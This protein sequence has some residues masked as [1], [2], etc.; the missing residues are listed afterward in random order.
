M[1]RP[2]LAMK[3]DFLRYRIPE[4][5]GVKNYPPNLHH[6]THHPVLKNKKLYLEKKIL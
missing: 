2:E 1:S 6:H 5:T 4:H 3:G